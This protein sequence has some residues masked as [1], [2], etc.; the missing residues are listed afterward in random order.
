M[1]KILRFILSGSMK[2]D[3]ALGEARRIIDANLAAR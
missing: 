2:T 3:A 1:W